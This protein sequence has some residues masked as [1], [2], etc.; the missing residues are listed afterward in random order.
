MC[1]FDA[2][3]VTLTPQATICTPKTSNVC[4][5]TYSMLSKSAHPVSLDRACE[6]MGYTLYLVPLCAVYLVHLYLVPYWFPIG[7]LLVL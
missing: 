6:V 3:T 1:M 5:E 2:H 7:T 4:I